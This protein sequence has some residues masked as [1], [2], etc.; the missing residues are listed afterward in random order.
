MYMYSHKNNETGE[1]HI[2]FYQKTKMSTLISFKTLQLRLV[3]SLFPKTLRKN[4]EASKILHNH[5]PRHMMKLL[6]YMLDKFI[7]F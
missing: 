3:F 5:L 6:L 4:R 2:F 1:V 7:H